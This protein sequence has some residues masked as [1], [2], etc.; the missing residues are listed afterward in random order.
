MRFFQSAAFNDNMS[1]ADSVISNLVTSIQ[2]LENTVDE[3]KADLKR[4]KAESHASAGQKMHHLPLAA[5]TGDL[6]MDW[7]D[8]SNHKLIFQDE[9]LCQSYGTYASDEMTSIAKSNFSDRFDRG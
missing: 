1:A 3:L 7:D 6:K 9:K 4:A 8:R 5:M 2:S